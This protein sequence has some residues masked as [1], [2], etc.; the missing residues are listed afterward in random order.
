MEMKDASDD[1]P[2]LS[3]VE[4]SIDWLDD[5]SLFGAPSLPSDEAAV[6]AGAGASPFK[7]NLIK[8]ATKE[9]L[10]AKIKYWINSKLDSVKVLSVDKSYDLCLLDRIDHQA[11]FP[12][13]SNFPQAPPH[14]Q[15]GTETYLPVLVNGQKIVEGVISTREDERT[16]ILRCSER[17]YRQLW[18][19]RCGLGK[20]V[21]AVTGFSIW[22]CPIKGQISFSLLQLR[23]PSSTEDT[24]LGARLPL[25][26][27]TKRALL[28]DGNSLVDDLGNFLIGES[29][30]NEQNRSPAVTFSSAGAAMILSQRLRE[31]IETSPE[32]AIRSTTTG[33]VVV[34]CSSRSAVRDLLH[35]ESSSSK[36]LMVDD[37]RKESDSAWY[38]KCKTPVSFGPFW[39][40]ANVAINGT[41]ARLSTVQKLSQVQTNAACK[42]LFMHPWDAIVDPH[43]HIVVVRD[44]GV[45]FRGQLD[46]PK[47]AH[48][49]HTLV[50][51]TL[52]FQR[53]T[54]LV[55]GDIHENNVLWRQEL[56]SSL[57][58]IDWDEALPKKPCIRLSPTEEEKHRYP[59]A[60]VDFPEAYT[61]QQFLH[62]FHDLIQEYYDSRHL[63]AWEEYIGCGR[64]QEISLV[65]VEGRFP[66]LMRFLVDKME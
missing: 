19:W 50:T 39:D 38:V 41:R 27:T 48:A 61:K 29:G 34:W 33:S 55:H 9:T 1:G 20:P 51:E 53:L 62:L 56:S 25:R 21:T 52:I 43:R 30:Q 23:M 14:L 8:F 18:W 64:Q 5:D 2:L 40:T 63:V 35:R 58:L 28:A 59:R 22:T 12:T 26:V 3:L 11:D 60:L 42:W 54:L 65:T 66:A 6:A 44:M 31:R 16:S 45:P 37:S 7:G 24:L 47:F 57:V 36:I 46:W 17:L 4:Q 15:F 13:K 49:Y 10:L 32:Y